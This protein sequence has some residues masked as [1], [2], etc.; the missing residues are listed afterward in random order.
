MIEA[1]F[2]AAHSA[3]TFGA[4]DGGPSFIDLTASSTFV[5]ATRY[6]QIWFE[7]RQP[8]AQSRGIRE[9]HAMRWAR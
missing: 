7:F 3:R 4:V 2:S 1:L 6:D 8:G 9:V 5:Y